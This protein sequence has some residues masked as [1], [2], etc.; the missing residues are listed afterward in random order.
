MGTLRRNA[1]NLVV[2]VRMALALVAV[3]LLSAGAGR[4]RVAGLLLLALAAFLDG[5]D[6]YLARRLAIVSPVGALL[7]TLGDRVTENALFVFLAYEGLVPL[8]VPLLFLTRSFLADF[9]RSLH[10]RRGVSGTFAMNTSRIGRALVASRTSRAGYLLLKFGVFLGGGTLL[11]FAGPGQRTDAGLLHFL[12]AGVYWG[13]ILA[14]GIN[15]LRF[16]AL[17]HDS[18]SVLRQEFGR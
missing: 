1:A 2:L 13:A 6:G 15:L 12:A 18:R 17:L 14:V 4:V 11:A 16:A 3:A 8:A 10:D 7:D 9:L 5:L